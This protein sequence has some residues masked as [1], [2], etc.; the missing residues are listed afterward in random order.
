MNNSNPGRLQVISVM[1]DAIR[2]EQHRP[3]IRSVEWAQKAPERMATA[4]LDAALPLITKILAK[5]VQELYPLGSQVLG[6]ALQR[7]VKLIESDEL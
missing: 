1:A 5:K 6:D 7:I 4:A 2:R 3:A